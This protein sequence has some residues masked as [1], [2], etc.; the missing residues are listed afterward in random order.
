MIVSTCSDSLSGSHSSLT[1]SE[2]AW[3]SAGLRPRRRA[4]TYHEALNTASSNTGCTLTVD[5]CEEDS[6]GRKRRGSS[7][8]DIRTTTTSSS[9]GSP[10]GQNQ[11]KQHE[12]G[13]KKN[14]LEVGKEILALPPPCTCPYFGQKREGVPKPAEV[15]IVPSDKLLL[16]GSIRN[17]TSE[18][19]HSGSSVS[20][21]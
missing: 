10:N 6:P 3:S 14:C 8:H 12:D 7:F 5:D 17:T 20:L 9:M 11:Q 4:S 16:S 13:G 15:K 19:D 18:D 2:T 21:R 1:V